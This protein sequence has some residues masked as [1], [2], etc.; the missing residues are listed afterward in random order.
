MCCTSYFN[1]KKTILLPKSL[2]T[3]GLEVDNNKIISIYSSNN[4]LPHFWIWLNHL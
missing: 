4:N 2:I 3:E 1:A